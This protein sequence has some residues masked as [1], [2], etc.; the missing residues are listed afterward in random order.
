[1][2]PFNAFTFIQGLETLPLR[3]QRHCENAEKVANYLSNHKK[4]SKVIYP[5]LMKGKYLDRA[6]IFAK[7]FWSI[8]RF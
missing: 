6:K 5:S 2:S 4:V 8:S 1:M 7:R 3:M